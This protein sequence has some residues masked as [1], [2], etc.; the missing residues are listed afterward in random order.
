MNSSSIYLTSVI[1]S[2]V[3]RLFS[4][5]YRNEHVISKAKRE[6]GGYKG[7][8]FVEILD[9]MHKLNNDDSAG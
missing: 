6:Y 3:L 7:Q 8:A 2:I 1:P 4:R 5:K 9:K